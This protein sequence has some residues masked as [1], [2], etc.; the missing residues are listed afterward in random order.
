MPVEP[1]QPAPTPDPVPSSVL[2]PA[3]AHTPASVPATAPA[4]PKP[5]EPPIHPF[6]EVP[7][8]S[9]RPPHERNFAAPPPKP[10]DKDSM[11]R[12]QAPV[13]DKKIADEVYARS[14]T[15]PCVTLSPQEL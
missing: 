11:Y 8:T 5:T 13:Q 3:L 4:I 15:T 9:Y 7:E 6:A 2:L 12:T 14:M 1:T 10:K